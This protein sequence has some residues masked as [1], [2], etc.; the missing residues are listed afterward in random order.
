MLD[1]AGNYT[2][3]ASEAIDMIASLEASLKR[4]RTG[5]VEYGLEVAHLER[6]DDLTKIE[7]GFPHDFLARSDVKYAL[8]GNLAGRIRGRVRGL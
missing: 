8:S 6:L 3:G 7:P 4:L 2:G 5:Y 1:T